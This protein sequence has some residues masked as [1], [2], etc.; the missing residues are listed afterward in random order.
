MAGL[1]SAAASE[2]PRSVLLHTL[3]LIPCNNNVFLRKKRKIRA[4]ARASRGGDARALRHA[5]VGVDPF[6]FWG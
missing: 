3:H 4:F 5:S 6:D 2:Q 1:P